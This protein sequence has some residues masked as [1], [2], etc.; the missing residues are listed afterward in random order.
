MKKNRYISVQERVWDTEYSLEYKADKKTGKEYAVLKAPYTK[1]TSDSNA[2]LA[3]HFTKIED[4]KVLKCVERE[5]FDKDRFMIPVAGYG[6]VHVDAI[7]DKELPEKVYRSFIDGTY[8]VPYDF[9]LD[10]DD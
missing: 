1:W 7:A 10:E 9:T 3:F 4:K 5:F 8:Q 6:Y 2:T